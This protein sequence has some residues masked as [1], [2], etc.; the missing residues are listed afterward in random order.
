[1]SDEVGDERC[2]DLVLLLGGTRQEKEDLDNGNE[3]RLHCGGQCWDHRRGLEAEGHL[4]AAD[5]VF[6]R[7]RGTVILH[8][9][10]GDGAVHDAGEDLL[11]LPLCVFLMEGGREVVDEKPVIMTE[12]ERGKREG[13]SCVLLLDNE[14]RRRVGE[15]HLFSKHTQNH[16]CVE[17]SCD[18]G[19]KP[20]KENKNQPSSFPSS[21][22]V[23][24]RYSPGGQCYS[25]PE[26][27]RACTTG[28]QVQ[29]P[30]AKDDGG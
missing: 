18:G 19:S 13:R 10:Q 8:G 20:R 12:K 5:K 9:C 4:H 21:R 22:H 25:E 14:R 1:V 27:R 3:V 26:A 28:L 2:N 17:Q 16:R 6:D 24:R 30:T 23:P 29:A 7:E 15:D 11:H